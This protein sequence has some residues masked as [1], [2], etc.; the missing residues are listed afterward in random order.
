[1]DSVSHSLSKSTSNIQGWNYKALIKIY[2]RF[3]FSIFHLSKMFPTFSYTRSVTISFPFSCLIILA[4]TCSKILNRCVENRHLGLIPD[5]K[6]KTFDLS[7]LNML[8]TEFFMDSLYLLKKFPSCQMLFITEKGW[9]LSNALFC[10]FFCIYWDDH[11]LWVFLV[12]LF[13]G[14]L[15]Y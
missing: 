12:F 1:M 9:I 13:F 2:L 6:S 4:R 3:F 15:F 5:L 7:S 11:G 10:L 8:L 14:P